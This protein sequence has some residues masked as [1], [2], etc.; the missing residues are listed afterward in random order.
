[1]RRQSSARRLAVD[2]PALIFTLETAYYLSLI[3]SCYAVSNP[4]INDVK[5]PSNIRLVQ[6]IIFAYLIRTSSLNVHS[7]L[8][9]EI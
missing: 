1:M 9:I 7:W 3:T 6:I 5:K 8:F 2:I 4:V